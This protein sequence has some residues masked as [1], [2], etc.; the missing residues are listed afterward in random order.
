MTGVTLVNIGLMP[1][2]EDIRCE[3]YG[4]ELMSE[5]LSIAAVLESRGIDVDFREYGSF[6]SREPLERVENFT[7]LLEGCHELVIIHFYHFYLP[8]VILAVREFKKRYPASRVFLAGKGPTPVASRIM[9]EF[10]WI[11]GV[12]CGEA[13]NAALSLAAGIA[14]R[15]IAGV[16]FR[17]GGTVMRTPTL[18]M[19]DL[20]HLPPPA[21]H[22]CNP[23][24][25]EQLHILASRGCVHGCSYCYNET[26][27]G[28]HR[29]V[30][31]VTNVVAEIRTLRNEYGVRSIILEDDNFILGNREWGMEFARRLIRERLDI[32]WVTFCR[33]DEIDEELLELMAQSGLS[34]LLLG[35]ETGSESILRH[36]SKSASVSRGLEAVKMAASR[37]ANLKITFMWGFPFETM[38]DLQQTVTCMALCAERF[39][40]S[41]SFSMVVPMPATRLCREHE[42]QIFFSEEVLPFNKSKFYLRPHMMD[43]VRKHGDIFSCFYTFDS[44]GL[45][46]KVELLRRLFPYECFSG[47]IQ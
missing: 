32:S 15:D 30:R 1:V 8:F 34:H 5:I 42:G 25:Y 10:P 26:Y 40:A 41:V 23:C 22:L 29:A 36:A 18:R 21:Y 38:E 12:L 19:T 33:V 27:W 3:R 9:E 20:D 16:C 39:K 6:A 47:R 44:P 13:E 17:D 28:R 31:P 46:Q 35:L 37:V 24:M 2:M 43:L 4:L 11:D 14:L 45:G 7:A